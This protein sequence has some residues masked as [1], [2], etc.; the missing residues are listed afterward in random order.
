MYYRDNTMIFTSSGVVVYNSN[1]FLGEFATTEEA[2][3]YIDN[4]Y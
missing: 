1:G 4:W 3:E 2:M